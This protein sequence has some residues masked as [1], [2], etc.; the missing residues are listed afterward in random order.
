MWSSS[1]F[2]GAFMG[3]T[4][5]GLLVESLAFPATTVV[6]ASVIAVVVVMDFG[7]IVLLKSSQNYRLLK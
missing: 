6:F 2:C 1:Y 3:P 4:L 5:G 7:E